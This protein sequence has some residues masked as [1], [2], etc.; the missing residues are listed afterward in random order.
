MRPHGTPFA[1]TP[2]SR[3]FNPFAMSSIGVATYNGHTVDA[4]PDAGVFER[5]VE[6]SVYSASIM[7]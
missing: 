5:C 1:I 6:A 3:G 4:D 2:S 7:M